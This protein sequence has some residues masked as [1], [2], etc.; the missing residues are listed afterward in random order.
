MVDFTDH[1]TTAGSRIPGSRR[2]AGQGPLLTVA[3]DALELALQPA[4]AGR[5]VV[6]LV[7]GVRE[8][9]TDH[10]ERL[11]ELVEV[12]AEAAEPGLDLLGVP[13]DAQAPEPQH[14]DP[15]VGVERV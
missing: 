9:P 7:A 14:D 3:L 12:P 5:G 13:L 1:T 11:P 8:V 2:D 15:Q 4:Q 6:V 10:V